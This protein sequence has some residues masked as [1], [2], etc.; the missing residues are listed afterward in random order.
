MVL[1]K[2]LFLYSVYQRVAQFVGFVGQHLAPRRKTWNT[3]DT[4]SLFLV[5]I[6]VISWISVDYTCI[7]NYQCILIS[8]VQTNVLEGF[9]RGR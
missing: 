6:C 4:K 7:D 2:Y 8:K 1:Y 9:Y 3:L 5:I